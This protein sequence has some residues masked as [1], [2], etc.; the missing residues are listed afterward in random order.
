MLY[1][2]FWPTAEKPSSIGAGEQHRE[3]RLECK[4]PIVHSIEQSSF[5]AGC[6]QRGEVGW[7]LHTAPST[8]RE[9]CKRVKQSIQ[10]VRSLRLHQSRKA[11]SL[12]MHSRLRMRMAEQTYGGVHICILVHVC[13]CFE[14]PSKTSDPAILLPSHV[15]TRRLRSDT[16]AGRLYCIC[17]I[18]L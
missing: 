18:A 10:R 8:I 2:V 7:R 11:V 16:K 15:S 5:V 3:H 13:I 1:S 12:V 14:A 6:H 17:K 9:M 4:M